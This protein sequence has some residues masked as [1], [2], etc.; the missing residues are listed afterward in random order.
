LKNK[1]KNKNR[2]NRNF[3]EDQKQNNHSNYVEKKIT[4]GLFDKLTESQKKKLG[5]K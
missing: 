5:I 3:T 4:I 1:N 2:N